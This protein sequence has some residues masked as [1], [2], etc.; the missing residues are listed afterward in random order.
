[1]FAIDSTP[2]SWPLIQQLEFQISEQISGTIPNAG[3]V[4]VEGNK[5]FFPLKICLLSSC[6]RDWKVSHGIYVPTP[7]HFL[8]TLRWM[9]LSGLRRGTNSLA[10]SE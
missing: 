1:M 6:Y 3:V 5:W 4:F 10:S 9:G 2:M 7:R 8:V